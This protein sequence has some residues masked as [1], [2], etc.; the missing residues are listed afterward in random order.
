MQNHIQK[1]NELVIK[2]NTEELSPAQIRLLKNINTL[3][4]HTLA[5]EDE[6]EY[7]DAS[8][9][10]L[11]KTAELIK[12]SSFVEKNKYMSFGEQAVEF[13]IDSLNES[14]EELMSNVDN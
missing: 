2:L 9:Q 8:A 4:I 5:A 7:F 10:L 6:A 14:L 11:R 13:A 3:L 12:Q 1:D